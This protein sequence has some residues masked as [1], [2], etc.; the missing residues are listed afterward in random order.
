MSLEVLLIIPRNIQ[1]LIWK[2]SFFRCSM[3]IIW[4]HFQITI[5]L[6]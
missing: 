4:F 6:A 3:N 1:G 5:N 2:T